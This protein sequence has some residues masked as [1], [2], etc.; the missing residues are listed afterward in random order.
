MLMTAAAIR[1]PVG[2]SVLVIAK[3][4]IASSQDDM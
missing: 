3:C 1:M 4:G 2:A